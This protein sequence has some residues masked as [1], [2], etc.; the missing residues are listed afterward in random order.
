MLPQRH[1]ETQRATI[2]ALS[3]SPWV[4]HSLSEHLVDRLL[5]IRS[6]CEM[7]APSPKKFSDPNPSLSR[8]KATYSSGHSQLGTLVLAAH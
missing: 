6:S 8:E 4:S 5:P 2:A 3:P 1:L 7:L